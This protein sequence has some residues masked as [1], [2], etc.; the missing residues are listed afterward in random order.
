MFATITYNPP[1]PT[2]TARSMKD[3]APNGP[4][5]GCQDEATIRPNCTKS[6]KPAEDAIVMQENPAYRATSSM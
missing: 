4:N 3:S 5:N 1:K 2:K 6:N